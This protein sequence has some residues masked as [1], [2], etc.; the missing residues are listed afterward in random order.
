MVI[1]ALTGSAL[2]RNEIDFVSV[3]DGYVDGNIQL[4]AVI[5]SFSGQ[6]EKQKLFLSDALPG[7]NHDDILGFNPQQNFVGRFKDRVLYPAQR[8]GKGPR[9]TVTLAADVHRG[10]EMF[11][12]QLATVLF[13]P[14]LHQ[15][16]T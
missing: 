13:G 4:Y 7:V 8:V 6:K 3:N 5:P 9:F 14:R 10:G 11:L 1:A 12:H 16:L 2:L 15:T